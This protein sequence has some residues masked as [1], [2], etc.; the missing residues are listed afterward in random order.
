MDVKTRRRRNAVAATALNNTAQRSVKSRTG[1]Q[2]IK[3]FVK[4]LLPTLFRRRTVFCLNSCFPTAITL[5]PPSRSS[6]TTRLDTINWFPGL[7]FIVWHQ[8]LVFLVTW[9]IIPTPRMGRSVSALQMEKVLS[10]PR[11]YSDSLF[12]T[13]IRNSTT[14]SHPL[15]DQ[16][17]LFTLCI[18]L[19]H[20]RWG[21]S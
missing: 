14:P 21:V 17:K 6:F 18:A 20:I 1:S 9:N 15:I 13:D 4:I 7:Q 10:P 16:A 11:E 2:N 12:N 8:D 5:S 3:K 19:V